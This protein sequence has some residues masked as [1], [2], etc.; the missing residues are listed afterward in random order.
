M[1]NNLNN[2]LKVL[3]SWNNSLGGAISFK[4]RTNEPTG[5]IMFNRGAT[6]GKVTNIKIHFWQNR[7]PDFQI[8]R[9]TIILISFKK[10][11]VNCALNDTFNNSDK[12][13]IN[14]SFLKLKI[15]PTL[16]YVLIM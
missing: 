15:I 10:Q 11:G 5:L 8:L 1:I 2:F 3:P 13:I 4:F 7:H 16:A 9:L 14:V 12:I 6:P